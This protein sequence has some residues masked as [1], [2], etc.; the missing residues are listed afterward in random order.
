MNIE[1]DKTKELVV[2]FS[3]MDDCYQ[4]ELME[5]AYILSLKQK[6]KKISIWN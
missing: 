6:Q 4:K 5:H 1:L 2:M 3:E